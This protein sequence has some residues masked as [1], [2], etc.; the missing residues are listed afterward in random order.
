MKILLVVTDK[1]SARFRLRQMSVRNIYLKRSI[2]AQ[3]TVLVLTDIFS[4]LNKSFTL[5]SWTIDTIANNMPGP[6]APKLWIVCTNT[7]SSKQKNRWFIQFVRL[8]TCTRTQLEDFSLTLSQSESSIVLMTCEL[9]VCV[10]TVR[11]WMIE[12]IDERLNLFNLIFQSH[13]N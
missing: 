5:P 8:Q 1:R 11:D 7:Q 12:I 9:N 2:F 10:S 4:F 3:Y 13:T 6:F